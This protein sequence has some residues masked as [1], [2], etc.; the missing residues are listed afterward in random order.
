MGQEE[1][2]RDAT[3]SVNYGVFGSNM[4]FSIKSLDNY[5]IVLFCYDYKKWQESQ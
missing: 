2:G 3:G 4:K 5:V 1:E